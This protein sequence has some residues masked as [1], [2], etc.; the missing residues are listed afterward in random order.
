MIAYKVSTRCFCVFRSMG[1]SF[2]NAA[3][4]ADGGGGWMRRSISGVQ[5]PQAAWR[6]CSVGQEMW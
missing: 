5:E 1:T 2:R 6:F 3:G 4:V